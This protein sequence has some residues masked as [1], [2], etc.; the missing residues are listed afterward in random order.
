[1]QEL[2]SDF[3]DRAL[4]Y[5]DGLDARPVAPPT[6]TSRGS[7]G[8]TGRCPTTRPIR[9]AVLQL[10]DEVGSPATVATTGR[11]YFGFV[12][13]G[14]LPAAL[15]ANLL[16]GVW[17]QNG[18]YRVHV[19]G[20]RRDRGGRARLG[21]RHSRRCPRAPGR[22]SRPVR[23]WR[24]SPRSPRRGTPCC[25]RRVGT[26]KT[27]ACSARR[28]SRVVVGDE[29]H[30]QRAQG[31]RRCWGSGATR[32]ERVAVDDQ[33]RMRADALPALYAPRPS[34]ASRPAT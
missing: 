3:S 17:D 5:I 9:A 20:R 29:V 11:R 30:A 26:S 12:T 21:A 14:S 22:G 31:A 16:A 25:R 7:R 34:S 10:L 27:T 15:A 23:R 4:R 13:G 8:S 28:R 18:A 1:M 32:V 19:A 6:R 33:G 24:T 2:L